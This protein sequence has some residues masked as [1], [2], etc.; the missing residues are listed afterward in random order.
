MSVSRGASH[1]HFAS[2][3]GIL[4]LLALWPA[5]VRAADDP[6]AWLARMSDA[7]EYLNYEGTLVHLHGGD[8]SVLRIAHRAENGRVTER[9][10]SE[11]AGR[12][13]IRTDDEVTCIFPDLRTVLIEKRDDSNREQS[14]LRVHLPGTSEINDTLYHLSFS[15]SRRIAGRDT[16]AIAIRSK[17]SFRYGYR[18][19]LDR[20]TAMPLQTQLLDEQ[21]EVLEQILFTEIELPE[22]IPGSAFEPS[23]PVESFSVRRAPAPAANQ[24]A[25]AQEGWKVKELPRGFA[26][27]VRNASV[28]PDS[29]NGLRHMVYSDGLAT[30]SLFVEP[31]VAASEQAEGLSQIGAANAYTTTYDGHMVT[32][33]GEVPARTVEIFARSAR[34]APDGAR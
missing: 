18:I 11:D 24:P 31:A 8:S 12:E 17:D 14:P 19:W 34:P 33:V 20:A 13:I 30:V 4:F 23:V 16:Q 25:R 15:G 26:L 10:T 29:G 21:G 9:I 6:R 32:A 28:M 2:A 3:S 22:R 5:I 1:A 7:V 27:T